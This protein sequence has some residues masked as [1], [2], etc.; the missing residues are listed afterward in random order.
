MEQALRS[1]AASA[2][3]V[4]ESVA[5]SRMPCYHLQCG[6]RAVRERTKQIVPDEGS[7]IVRS[8]ILHVVKAGAAVFVAGVDKARLTILEVS[9]ILPG[10][11]HLL[12]VAYAAD[13]VLRD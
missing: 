4:A 2:R 11:Q 12:M 1:M 6:H 8:P 3:E 5:P 7:Q 10:V 13:S 9:E